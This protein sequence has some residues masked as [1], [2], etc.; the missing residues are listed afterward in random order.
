MSTDLPNPNKNNKLH[1]DQKYFDEIRA[2]NNFLPENLYEEVFNT[3][4]KKP[5]TY[6]W[7]SNNAT[8]PHGHLNFD[9]ARANQDCIFDVYDRV[10]D[11]DR[12]VWDF[13]KEKYY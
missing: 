4:N 3:Y 13:I 12:K 8:D 11:V 5:L 2:Y 6:G 10:T 7:K 9:V 1:I